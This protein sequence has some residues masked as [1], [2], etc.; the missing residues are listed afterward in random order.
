MNP[1][2]L[3]I[4]Q[5]SFKDSP[6]LSRLLELSTIPKGLYIRGKLPTITLDAMGRASPRI[7]TV[8]GSRKNTSY[9]RRAVEHLLSTFEKDEVIILSG[10]AVGID[11]EAHKTAL[12]KNFRTIAIPGSGLGDYVLYPSGHKNLAKEILENNGV[13]ISELEDTT[14]A[15]KWT[16]VA[17]NRIMAA[18][19]DAVLIVEAEEKSGTLVTG[20]QALELGRDIG[21]VPG[22]IFSPTSGGPLSLIRDGA[23]PIT[24]PEDLR[25]LLNLPEKKSKEKVAL[26]LNNEEKII[27][28]LLR[29]PQ[30]K[31]ILLDNS[32]LPL[33]DFL[34]I[35]TT[36]EMK[37]YIEETFGEVRKIV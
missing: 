27:M 22:E 10:L 6:F 33:T 21:A 5:S 16:F 31:D 15:A 25:L 24:S 28:E 30:N 18:L 7:L 4:P 9:G 12:K 13:L 19:S 11:G 34:M 20:R 32:K 14:R 35:I 37:G 26:D 8:V 17:R 3:F 29:E 1:L 23:V 36:L 2:S